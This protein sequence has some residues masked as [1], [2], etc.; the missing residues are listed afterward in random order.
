LKLILNARLRLVTPVS[1]TVLESIARLV[2]PKTNSLLRK[3][4]RE[5]VCDLFF[6]Q[7]SVRANIHFSFM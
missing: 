6:T 7:A 2:V 3:Q 4:I 1:P 5:H